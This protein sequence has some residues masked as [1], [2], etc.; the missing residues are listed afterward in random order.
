MKVF[1]VDIFFASKTLCSFIGNFDFLNR[2]KK[3]M[4]VEHT[5]DKEKK[6][7]TCLMI[8]EEIK[9]YRILLLQNH[10]PILRS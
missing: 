8:L 9:K 4:F 3:R 10:R 7:R 6:G 1:S 2:K 5:F